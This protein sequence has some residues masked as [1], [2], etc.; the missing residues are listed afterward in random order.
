MQ[1]E[2]IQ[3]Q[4]KNFQPLI[5]ARFLKTDRNA[6]LYIWNAI[7][8][9]LNILLWGL[10]FEATK[11]NDPE[12]EKPQIFSRKRKVWSRQDITLF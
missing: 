12:G 5:L 7:S 2:I 1:E 8:H 4:W 10:S 3:Y 11:M 6:V 9:R